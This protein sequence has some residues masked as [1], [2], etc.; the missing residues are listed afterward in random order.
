MAATKEVLVIPAGY[1][2]LATVMRDL[3]KSKAT[4]D[5]LVAAGALGSTL[6]ERKG[7]K[8]ERVYL[9]ED[10][11]R[12][13][14][15][16]EQRA[17]AKPPPSEVAVRKNGATGMVSILPELVGL[18]RE[19]ASSQ[20]K[21]ALPEPEQKPPPTVPVTQKLWLTLDE[22]VEYSGLARADLV[23]LCKL[24]VLASQ[25]G[26]DPHSAQRIVVRKSNGWKIL[27]RSLEAFEG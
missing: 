24:A 3:G 21:L 19:L 9:A 26:L 1:L 11:A 8:D 14:R 6:V 27:R 20:R 13:K 18:L 5:R 2:G 16:A 10:V 23:N 22:A 7:R 25:E 15:E 4:V 17:A 12:L